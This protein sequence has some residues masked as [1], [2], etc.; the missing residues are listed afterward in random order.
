MRVWSS[1]LFPATLVPATITLDGAQ[2]LGALTFNNTNG[3]TLTPGL[4][5][6]GSLTMDNAG[7]PA[8]IVVSGGSQ[9][10]AADVALNDSL[11]I[12]PSAGTTLAIAGNISQNA[13]GLSLA[14]S[15][16]TPRGYRL[17]WTARAR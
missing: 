12:A 2:T 8:E 17:C 6:T 10:I 3:Y 1:S 9:A 4:S 7:S 16:R 13:A 5:G 14:T 11:V 15:V